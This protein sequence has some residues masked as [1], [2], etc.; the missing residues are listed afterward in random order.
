MQEGAGE[1]AGR[2]LRLG[3]Y[4]ARFA[5]QRETGSQD[6]EGVMPLAVRFWFV[7]APYRSPRRCAR[8]ADPGA[9]L[10]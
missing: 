6:G 4:A 3:A 5:G 9:D 7:W 10:T 2:V 1:Q 8:Q